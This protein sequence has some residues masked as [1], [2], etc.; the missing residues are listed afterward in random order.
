MSAEP[1][2][3]SSAFDATINAPIKNL[4]V[5][6]IARRGARH[7]G[8]G[9]KGHLRPFA[10]FA[11]ANVSAVKALCALPNGHLPGERTD[12][13]LES[14]AGWLAHFELLGCGYPTVR[15][16]NDHQD[17]SLAVLSVE[18]LEGVTN[19]DA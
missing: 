15:T 4:G 7:C 6:A 8:W 10:G 12:W 14:R 17:V 16:A 13:V 11:L 2:Q 5:R 9:L 18:G 3:C 1:R 19:G